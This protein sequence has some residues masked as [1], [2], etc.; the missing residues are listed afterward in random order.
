MVVVIGPAA[1]LLNVGALVLTLGAEKSFEA[2]AHASGVIALSTARACPAGLRPRAAHRIG[3]GGAL[4]QAAVG[5]AV[6]QVAL[7]SH[8]SV[9]VPGAGILDQSVLI[10][11]KTRPHGVVHARL[12]NVVERFAGAVAAATVRAS[13]SPAALA[14]V[15]REALAL[16]AVPVADTTVGALRLHRVLVVRVQRR[17]PRRPIRTGAFGAIRALPRVHQCAVLVAREAGAAV[18][19]RSRGVVTVRWLIRRRHR[20]V[21]SGL[22]RRRIR[23]FVVGTTAMAAARVR[24]LARGLSSHHHAKHRCVQ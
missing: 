10:L 6:A 9:C 22:V 17:V 20:Y 16:A 8:D 11:D 19:L 14:G 1:F 5:S 24:T 12:G 7:T 13:R 21:R 23:G 2:L 4:L 15:A 3:G 18:L